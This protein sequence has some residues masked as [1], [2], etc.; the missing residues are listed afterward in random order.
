MSRYTTSNDIVNLWFNLVAL[1][2]K[3]KAPSAWF[4][5]EGARLKNAVQIDPK[6]DINMLTNSKYRN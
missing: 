6:S 2:S 4:F 5:A 1:L 3:G